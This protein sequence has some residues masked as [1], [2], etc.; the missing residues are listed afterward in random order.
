MS[1]LAFSM[2]RIFS[3]SLYLRLGPGCLAYL[4]DAAWRS[5][6]LSTSSEALFRQKAEHG[7]SQ[8]LCDPSK[9]DKPHFIM[10]DE[11]TSYLKAGEA[12]AADHKMYASVATNRSSNDGEE[13]QEN[14]QDALNSSFAKRVLR[15][16]DF[17]IIPLLFVTYNFNFMDK[18]IL[19]SASVFGLKTSTVCF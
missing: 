1:C 9:F 3:R 4:K 14:S 18:T 13:S 19:S 8:P 5:L 15:K 17:R 6:S 7:R 2:S 12:N 10:K 11:T 16:I